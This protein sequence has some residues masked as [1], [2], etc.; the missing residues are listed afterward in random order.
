MLNYP[1][2]VKE[3]VKKWIHDYFEE[4]GKGCF[5]VIGIFVSDIERIHDNW[6]V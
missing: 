4:N 5:A 1:W 6:R 2:Q 3:D